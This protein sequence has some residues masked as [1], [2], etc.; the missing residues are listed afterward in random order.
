MAVEVSTPGPT[1]DVRP[2]RSATC[3]GW[4]PPS[5]RKSAKVP[6]GSCENVP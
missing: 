5:N 6:G 4:R 2:V 1:Q 3:T